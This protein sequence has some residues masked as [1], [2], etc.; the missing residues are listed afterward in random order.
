MKQCA[1]T[2]TSSLEEPDLC[3][4]YG[5]MGVVIA[6]HLTIEHQEFL[7]EVIEQLQSALQPPKDQILKAC[8]RLNAIARGFKQEVGHDIKN[9]FAELIMNVLPFA[10]SDP[11]IR[12]EVLAYFQKCVNILG[13]DMI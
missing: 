5:L 13:T 7:K 4:L 9:I 3:A 2:L 6:H 10:K 8:G 12:L 11:D 1:A